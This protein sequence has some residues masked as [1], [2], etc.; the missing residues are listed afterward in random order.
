MWRTASLSLKEEENSESSDMSGAAGADMV[1]VAG[2]SVARGGLNRSEMAV[3]GKLE[4]NLER[5]DSG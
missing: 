5:E 1:V 4:S 3:R 2:W